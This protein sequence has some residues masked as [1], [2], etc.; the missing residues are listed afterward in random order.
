[1]FHLFPSTLD[2]PHEA[3]SIPPLLHGLLPGTGAACL[4][5]R[6]HVRICGTKGASDNEQDARPDLLA[7][8]LKRDPMVA[9]TITLLHL[10]DPQFG[11]EHLFG[12]AGLTE[13]EQHRDY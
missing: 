13:A 6:R 12:S 10:S 3:T 8:G 1:M 2:R 7:D 11:K 9:E 4:C 5:H